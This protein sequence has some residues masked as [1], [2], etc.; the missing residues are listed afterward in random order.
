MVANLEECYSVILSDLFSDCREDIRAI[1]AARV[2][3]LKYDLFNYLD[4][5]GDG[6][7]T[8]YFNDH[9]IS[10]PDEMAE[11]IAYGLWLHLNS[12]KCELEDV[13]KFRQ[14][15]EGKTQ[16]Y[17]KSLNDCFQFLSINLSDEEVEQFKQTNE[18]DINFF[19]HFGL[20]SYIRSNFGLFCGTAPLTKFFIEKE[21]FHPDDMS[22]IILYGFW[23]YL[24]SKP[25]DYESAS[26]FYEGLRTLT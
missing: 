24:N 2:I 7:L 6:Q 8:Q 20:G 13:Y 10:D 14:S 25:C 26:Q 1:D 4:L 11:I 9:S 17:P 21:L 3:L 5:N 22:T 16:D 15:M 19:F 12:E 18:K 23:L